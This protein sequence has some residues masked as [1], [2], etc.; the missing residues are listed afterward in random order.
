MIINP[1]ISL[2]QHYFQVALVSKG[3]HNYSTGKS[4]KKNLP[5]E[6]GLPSKIA[7]FFSKMVITSA[8]VSTVFLGK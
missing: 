3:G 7:I 1:N 8:L 5:Y 4:E 2:N 6:K